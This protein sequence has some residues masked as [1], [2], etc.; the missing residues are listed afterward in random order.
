MNKYTQNLFKNFLSKC[1]RQIFNI[2]FLSLKNLFKNFACDII[3]L[4]FWVF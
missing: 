2:C 4:Y 1:G 3:K